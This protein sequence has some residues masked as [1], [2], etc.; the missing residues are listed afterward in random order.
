MRI[1]NKYDV[2]SVDY[3]G[4]SYFP[5]DKS[6]LI[7]RDGELKATIQG[8]AYMGGKLRQDTFYICPLLFIDLLTVMS[9]YL[10]K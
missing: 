3:E 7:K 6:E 5:Q 2:P 4:I 10:N 9:K 1:S 8:V